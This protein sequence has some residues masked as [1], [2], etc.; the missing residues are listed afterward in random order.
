MDGGGRG[1]SDDGGLEVFETDFRPG[2]GG[3]DMM[4][5]C[6]EEIWA[7]YETYRSRQIDLDQ[8]PRPKPAAMI[9]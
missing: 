6:L 5:A 2:G 7:R 8:M 9:N 3:R 4:N 1:G